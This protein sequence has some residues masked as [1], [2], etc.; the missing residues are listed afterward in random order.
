VV[1]SHNILMSETPNHSER[2]LPR[3]RQELDKLPLSEEQK[4]QAIPKILN[5]VLFL[6]TYTGTRT[7]QDELRED[8]SIFEFATKVQA[9][10]ERFAAEGLTT[11]DYLRAALR[12]PQLFCQKPTTIAGNIA[13]VVALFT[14]Q[15]LTVTDYLRAA[16]KRPQLFGQK[17]ATI[18]ANIAGVVALFTDQGL[19]ATDYLRAALKQPRLFC[20]KPATIAANV[21]G[22]VALFADQ[23]LT[24][25]DYLRAALKRPQLFC[26]KPATI[27]ANIAGVVALFTDQGLTV[28]DYLRA[29]L[30]QPQL[31][32]QKPAA[33]VSNIAGLVERFAAKGLT[34]SD[35]LRAALKRPQLFCH[36]PAT[37][38]RHIE[39]ILELFDEGVVALPRSLIP[40]HQKNGH[41][42]PHA[43]V[44]AYLLD[45]SPH[46]LCFDDKNIFLRK[47]H[48]EL[49]GAPASFQNLHRSRNQTE[50][51]L[52]R[53]LG[54]DDP[55]R[56]VPKDANP[57]LVGLIRDGYIKGAKIEG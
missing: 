3:I 29:A 55:A 52:M 49:T 21:A 24:V 27:A 6:D 28:T 34:R 11:K 5:S 56:P 54:H 2:F 51:E 30:R 4:A 46:Y 32:Y 23:G 40:S 15:G 53:H 57:V 41:P 8:S 12:Q 16:Q 43:L 7:R 47:L 18:A 37:V 36:K 45:M 44:L 13:G 10:V 26:Q 19:T 35:Y 9:V 22:V 1:A 48:K 38:A 25:T 50:L 33:I 20:H 39:L 31:F 14:D 17:P 42:H